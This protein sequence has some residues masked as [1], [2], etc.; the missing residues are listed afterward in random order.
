MK[1]LESALGIRICTSRTENARL[2]SGRT[3]D[4]DD[5]HR[6]KVRRE[7][8]RK[9]EKSATS[10]GLREGLK[11]LTLLAHKEIET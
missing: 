9:I 5:D 2:G 8:T 7:W 1:K 3:T 10:S 4:I 6:R 11:D